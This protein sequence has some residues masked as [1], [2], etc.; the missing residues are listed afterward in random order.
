MAAHNEFGKE[1]EQL[2][3]DWLRA[4]GYE[5]LYKNWRYRYHE[6]DIVAKKGRKLH[7]VEVKARH[8]SSYGPPEIAVGRKKFKCLKRATDEFLFQNPDYKWIQYDILAITLFHY[9]EPE[10]FLLEDVFLA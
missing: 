2:A 4:K 8:H 7:I 1:A 5:I 9:K 6:I 3:L 10:F